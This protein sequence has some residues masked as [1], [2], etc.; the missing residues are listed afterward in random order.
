MGTRDTALPSQST[1]IEAEHSDT[2]YPIRGILDESGHKYL[3][4]WEGD[5]DPTWEPKHFV[6]DAAI[7]AWELKKSKRNVTADRYLR[8]RPLRS[9]RAPYINSL[10]QSSVASTLSASNSG[11][12]HSQSS[13]S[14]FVPQ[15][16]QPLSSSTPSQGT[17]LSDKSFCQSSSCLATQAS[18]ASIT[19]SHSQLSHPGTGSLSYLSQFVGLTGQST[20]SDC[21]PSNPSAP[22]SSPGSLSLALEPTSISSRIIEN[23]AQGLPRARAS[24]KRFSKPN[25]VQHHSPRP[26]HQRPNQL[27]SG[28]TVV[29]NFSQ[30]IAETPASRLQIEESQ[31]SQPPRRIQFSNSQ[32]IPPISWNNTPDNPS[33]WKIAHYHLP[34]SN[35]LTIQTVPETI[36]HSS[37]GR[38]EAL[39]SQAFIEESPL[40]FSRFNSKSRP[41]KI[42]SSV[43]IVNSQ[44]Q[45]GS[46]SSL[47][48]GESLER[49]K[50]H[51]EDSEGTFYTMEDSPSK[52]PSH[53]PK[54]VAE[55][56]RINPGT[57]YGERMRF[58]RAAERASIKPLQS[59][60][61]SATPSS[62]GDIEPSAPPAAREGVSPLSVRHDKEL[63]VRVEDD[64][65]LQVPFVAPQALHYNPDQPALLGEAGARLT[66]TASLSPPAALELA[67][68]QL[69]QEAAKEEQTAEKPNRI[70][71][72]HYEFAIPLS[73]DSRVKDDY[74]RTL[75]EA[76]KSI[77]RFLTDISTA[78]P[79][80]LAG[81]GESEVDLLV[82]QM[83]RMIA[84]LDNIS[85]HPDLN[86]LDQ[87][88]SGPVDV[89]KEAS[90]AEY[91][92][93]K[94]QYLGYFI[95]TVLEDSLKRAVHVVIMAQSGPTIDVLKKYFLGK[96]LENIPPEGLNKP[97]LVFIS[98]HLSFEIRTTGDGPT[99]TPFKDP[100]MIVAFDSSFDVD[101]ESVRELRT[102]ASSDR[103]V[104]VIRLIISNTAE[105]IALCLPECSDL[106]RLRLLVQYTKAYQSIAG[107][108]QDD[109]L[110][111]QENAEETFRYI[112]SDPDTREWRLVEVDAVEI[113]APD[114]VS[115]LEP[116]QLR[117]MSSSRQK[118]WLEDEGDSATNSS[119][120]QRMTP[121]QDITHISDS[122]KGQTQES[123]TERDNDTI[124]EIKELRDALADARKGLQAME[125]NFA[126]L[127]HRYESKHEL[128]HKTRQELDQTTESAKKLEI[129]TKKQEAEILK[130]KDEKS[131]LIQDLEDARNVIK[132][133][134]GLPADL[135][136]AK[137]EI[138][139]I[140]KEKSRLER[141]SQQERSQSEFTR[142]QYQSAS[143]A[144]AQSGL[145]NFQLKEQIEILKQQSSGE[146]SR[147]KEL[148]IKGDEKRNFERIEELEKLLASREKLLT[149]KEEEIRELKKNRP[150]TRSTSTQPRS[151][152]F[153]GSSRAVSPAPNSTTNSNNNIGRGSVLRFRVEP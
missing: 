16:T 106:D 62:A 112:V 3:V 38:G 53:H 74:D 142:Q 65:D 105:H 84:Q 45:R 54:T 92:S 70:S 82:P 85:T 52:S 32:S 39:G 4:A 25:P 6:N 8:D 109:A 153:A 110:G 108:L 14:V 37:K 140:S 28:E 36:Y 76:G 30:E 104:P 71:L 103:L 66:K 18:D 134:G 114:N 90:W 152:K 68:Q 2:E 102:V 50:V 120:R 26:Y 21:G 63:P 98:R 10:S 143:T 118:R 96:R 147:L 99:I 119:K 5:Y 29:R 93:S 47:P 95:D 101:E 31:E 113:S 73:M 27:T 72:G 87:P 57:T 139:N 149:M 11:S 80:E 138:R 60:T 43:D 128:Y 61:E 67:A 64:V 44:V 132:G 20:G 148:R 130:L 146:A 48:R 49:L 77:R 122:M 97:Q 51:P 56:A 22:P 116:E 13:G 19:E 136:N 33:A 69:D 58:L 83:R 78:E 88:S 115:S 86:L 35:S 127:Q 123:K 94:F 79:A 150:A 144:A 59:L 131:A 107:D 135:E 46:H 9:C 17:S 100:T 1:D 121:F 126:K 89:E 42:G 137:E 124:A 41:S 125:A 133:G 145:E 75:E 7:H 81:S 151:P 34:S 15:F 40:V 129:R 12:Q 141:I 117:A 91:S 55:A 24:K 23:S 111:V